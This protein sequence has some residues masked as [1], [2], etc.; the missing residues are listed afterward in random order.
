MVQP[1]LPP[2]AQSHY[3]DPYHQGVLDEA[4]HTAEGLWDEVG[5]LCIDLCVD[6]EGLIIE[7]WFDGDGSPW[8]LA[9]ASMLVE[10]LEGKTLEDV[11]STPDDVHVGRC[12]SDDADVQATWRLPAELVRVKIVE[13]ELEMESAVDDDEDGS[14]FFG[15]NLGEEC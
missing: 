4:T 7:A 15:P 14:Q 9:S 5:E 12:E 10:W 6:T 8:L 1:E 11:G 3:E 13:P 2:Q